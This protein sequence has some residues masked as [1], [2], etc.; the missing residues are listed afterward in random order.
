MNTLHTNKKL[1]AGVIDFCSILAWTNPTAAT[2]TLK[3]GRT[4]NG[5]FIKPDPIIYSKNMRHFLNVLNKKIFRN[6][7]RRT[8]IKCIPI[9]EGCSTKRFHYH[10]ALDCPEK[11]SASEFEIAIRSTWKDTDWGYRTMDVQRCYNDGWISYIAKLK[12]KEAYS[13]AIDWI[14]VVQ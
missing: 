1:R 9:L 5:I 8:R 7:A 11:I 13:D 12:T 10:L 6:R 2:L 3:E 4:T 14:N